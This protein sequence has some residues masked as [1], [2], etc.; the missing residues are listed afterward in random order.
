MPPLY[1]EIIEVVLETR[2]P[3]SFTRSELYLSINFFAEKSP[4]D[5]KLNSLSMKYLRASL[6]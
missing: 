1:L 5:P 6:P 4:S 3:R 2:L